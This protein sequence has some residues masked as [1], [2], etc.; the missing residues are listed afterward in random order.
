MPPM[1]GR[2]LFAVAILILLAGAVV[3]GYQRYF[4]T[5]LGILVTGW[6]FEGIILDPAKHP[7][8]PLSTHVWEVT[9]ADIRKMEAALD[10][11]IHHDKMLLGSRIPSELRNYRRRYFGLLGR[12]NEELIHVFCAHKSVTDRDYWLQN[13]FDPS[14]G[15]DNYWYITYDMYSSSFIDFVVNPPD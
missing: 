4:T 6:N 11:H 15:G 1:K 2:K 12:D 8:N 13:Y 3:W 10:A 5:P 9:P 14:G 7:S